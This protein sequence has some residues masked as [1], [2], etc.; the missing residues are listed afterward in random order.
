MLIDIYYRLGGS[1]DNLGMSVSYG[2]ERKKV[3]QF[4]CDIMAT[5]GYL[6]LAMKMQVDHPITHK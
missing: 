5:C 3:L 4:L 1:E 6:A 2:E